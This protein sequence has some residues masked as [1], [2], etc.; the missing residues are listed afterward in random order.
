MAKAN[1]VIV[2]SPAKA[3]TIGKYLGPTYQVLAS[4]GHVRDLPK[5]KMGVDLETGEF[6]P[7]Y[8]PIKGKEETIA[9]LKDAADHSKKVYLATDPDREGEAISWHLMEALKLSGKKVYRITFNEITKLEKNGMFVYESVPGTAVENFKASADEV[10]F[11]VSADKDIQVTLELEADTEY[12]IY[13]DD[14]NIGT[15]KTNL[16]GKISVSAEMDPGRTVEIK[17]KKK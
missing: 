14:V 3:K 4:M 11:N 7:Q 16:S 12:V 8:Q 10:V 15:M 13:M 6:E 17:V 2:E 9:Q 1:L 5:S